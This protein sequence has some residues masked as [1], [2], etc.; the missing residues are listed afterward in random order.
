VLAADMRETTVDTITGHITGFRDGIRKIYY[1]KKKTDV[2]ISCWGLAEVTRAGLP[3][4]DIMPYLAEF[5]RSFVEA[6]DSVDDIAGKLK[7]CLENVAPP[8]K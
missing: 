4:K 2:G 8:H 6:G 5:D 7:Q 3:D 1:V